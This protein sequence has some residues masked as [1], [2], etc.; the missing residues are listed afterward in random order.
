MS[1]VEYKNSSQKWKPIFCVHTVFI[2]TTTKKLVDCGPN[3][4]LGKV[5]IAA[6]GPVG[7]EEGWVDGGS[8]RRARSKRRALR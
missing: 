2:M 4:R 6:A 8:R 7:A 5:L 1:L 3:T